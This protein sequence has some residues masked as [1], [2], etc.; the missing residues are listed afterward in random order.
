MRTTYLSKPRKVSPLTTDHR[1]WYLASLSH[2]PR[3]SLTHW[4]LGRGMNRRLEAAIAIRDHI[5]KLLESEG[6]WTSCTGIKI[7]CWAR[8]GFD[9]F[10]NTPFN[11]APHAKPDVRRY[12]SYT[13]AIIAQRAK[14][15]M[16]YEL[17]LW[18]GRKVLSIEW[19]VT[20]EV[21]LISFR[22]GSWEQALLKIV[23]R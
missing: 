23:P 15:P 10:L 16:P 12:A 9:A 21:R 17:N 8:D 11:P 20:G 3:A 6:R 14:H 2:F 18:H 1:Q 7:W 13:R 4:R 5:L 19:Q 22:R